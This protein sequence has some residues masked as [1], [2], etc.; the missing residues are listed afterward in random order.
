MA[1][2]NFACR[3]KWIL[4]RR[5]PTLLNPLAHLIGQLTIGDLVIRHAH[6]HATGFLCA[7]SQPVRWPL[8]DGLHQ[9]IA[10]FRRVRDEIARTRQQFQHMHRGGGRIQP[11][12]VGQ[13]SVLV[14]IIRQHQRH[15]A[16][17]RHLIAQSGPVCRQFRDKSHPIPPCPI[18][19]DGAFGGLVKIGFAFEGNRAGQDA[20]V[21][22]GQGDVHGD[23][24][25]R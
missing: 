10:I 11:N 9:F 19:S 20:S 25:G 2:F 3:V 13:P 23:V 1:A 24:A 17:F 5:A 22:F 6:L 21:H 12:P 7:V 15:L 16:L 18:G 8:Q 14:R 4:F